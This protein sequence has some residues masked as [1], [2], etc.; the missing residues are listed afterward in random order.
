ML[1]KDAKLISVDDHLI[2]PPDTWSS[3]LPAKY[4]GIGPRIERRGDGREV[5]RYEKQEVPNSPRV[6]RLL[7]HV[8]EH[9]DAANFDEMRPGCYRAKD[10]L[11]EM[12]IDGVWA[13]LAF[14]N[15]ARFAGHRFMPTNDPELSLLC[16]QAYN[17]LL[18][19]E[20]CAVDPERLIPLMLIPLWDVAASV[21]EI[22]RLAGRGVKAVAFSENPTILGLPS[23]H[24]SHWEPVW[25]ALV[26]HDLAVCMHIGSSSKMLTSSADAPVGVQFTVVGVNSMI[27]MADWIFSGILD[28]FPT[29]RV[30]YSEGGAGWIPYLLEHAQKYVDSHGGLKES[31]LGRLPAE[32]FR[33][34]MFA[35]MVTDDFA[36]KNRYEIG[37]DN[38]LW[39]G[40]FPHGDGMYPHSRT[41]LA[42]VLADVPDDEARKIAGENARRALRL[43]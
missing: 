36:V 9:A 27:S 19:D 28:R 12:D 38:L 34:N 18:I 30:L 11:L 8:E 24:T 43:G 32:Y 25:R 16:T 5:W 7:P 20:W 35:C 23:I 10:R 41:N 13:Q 29:L 39:E 6:V 17:D 33:D 21:A 22:E 40:D 31:G 14:P 42:R 15:F 4:Q 3:R 2:E 37:V 1:P 26:E